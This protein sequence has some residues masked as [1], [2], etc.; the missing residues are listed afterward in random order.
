MITPYLE[1]LIHEGKARWKHWTCGGG[2]VM[3][4]PV[5]QDSY[6][7]IEKFTFSPFLDTR[8]AAAYTSLNAALRCAH[9]V[10]FYPKGK[11]KEF[12][13]NFRTAF[14]VN[15]VNGALLPMPVANE[16]VQDCYMLFGGNVNIDVWL[17][18]QP[19]SWNAATNGT[20]TAKAN[21]P[22]PPNGYGT[23]IN[24]LKSIDDINAQYMPATIKRTDIAPGN[25]R[26]Q[27]FFDIAAATALNPIVGVAGA[28]PQTSYQY[29]ILNISY[30]EVYEK[31]PTTLLN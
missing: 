17:L 8:E 26:E 31:A 1:K 6:I 2:G 12:Y 4:L 9:T 30:V 22:P 18:K 13:Y 29:P 14:N 27:L 11:G 15:N 19:Q 25:Y 24:T 23:T 10:K 3:T 16:H 28:A 21:E 7:V 20:Y 5:Q